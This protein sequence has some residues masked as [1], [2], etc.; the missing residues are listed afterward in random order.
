M[1][2][3]ILKPSNN[4]KILVIFLYLMVASILVFLP[5]S[6]HGKLILIFGLSLFLIYELL[7]ISLKFKKSVLA[8][9]LQNDYWQI[10]SK[11]SWIKVKLINQVFI[12][13][14][15]LLLV[16]KTKTTKYYSAISHDM[17]D[18]KMFR[19]LRVS[20]RIVE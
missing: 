9:R 19:K 3:F 4:Q 18:D 5:F 2:F 20:A 12:S 8:I 6:T 17:L 16:F 13:D 10:K 7:N 11:E 14:I 1:Q 15:F